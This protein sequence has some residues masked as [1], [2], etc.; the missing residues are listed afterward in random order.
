MPSSIISTPRSWISSGYGSPSGAEQANRRALLE[1]PRELDHVLAG[2][3]ALG[4]VHLP[5]KELLVARVERLREGLRLRTGVVHKVLALNLVACSGQHAREGVAERKAATVADVDR[6][7]GVRRDELDLQAGAPT[8]IHVAKG[9]PRI[10]DHIDL[11]GQPCRRQ[12]DV[13]EARRRHIHIRDR[14]RQVSARGFR[15]GGCDV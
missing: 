13:D 8:H 15:D 2:V 4:N 10:A 14:F 7:H 3:A 6:A 11:F 1:A 9:R 12:M 5:A